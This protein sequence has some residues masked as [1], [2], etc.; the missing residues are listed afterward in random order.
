L[1]EL[2]SRYRDEPFR[3]VTSPA[4]FAYLLTNGGASCIALYIIK[5]SDWTFGAATETGA[6]ASLIPLWQVM[7]AGFAAAAFFRSSFFAVRLGDKDVQVGPA[8]VLQIIT[9]AM[10]RAVDRNRA[11]QR[12]QAVAM[13]MKGVDFEMASEALPAH[14]V[15]LMQ[16]LPSEDIGKIGEAIKS[17]KEPSS[18]PPEVKAL[19][20]GLIL[21]NAVGEDVLK[22]AIES[23][24]DKIKRA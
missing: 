11:E 20:L 4:S 7:I 14:C 2:I 3:A 21:M 12:A 10:D 19:N 9:G 22:A 17:L 16:N 5:V 15:A 1:A 8:A 23:I 18:M 24:G 6:S 13:L